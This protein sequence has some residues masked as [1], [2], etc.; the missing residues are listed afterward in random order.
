MMLSIWRYSHLTLAIASFVFILLASV[1]G[2]ILAFEPISEQLKPYA[3]T[4]EANLGKTLQQLQNNYE[5]VLF[6]EIDQNGYASASVITEAGEN[7]TF[8]IHPET[9]EKVG[10]ISP[11]KEIYRFATNLHRSLFLKSLGRFF[12]GLAS[13]LLL[14][15]SIT[16]IFL[17]LKRQGGIRRFFSR[18]SKENR[19]QHNHVYLGRLFLIPIV[20]ITV[21]GTYLSLEKFEL[22]PASESSHQIDFEHIKTTPALPLNEFALFKSI[23]LSEVKRIEFPFSPDPEDYFTVTLKDRELLVNQINGDILSTVEFPLVKLFSNWSL[24][25]HTGRG[26]IV[27]SIILGLTCI[28]LLYFMYSGFAMTFERLRK[29][30]LIQNKYPPEAAEIVILVGSETGN[31]YLAASQLQKAL[32]KRKQKV[33]VDSMN[34]FKPFKNLKHLVILTAT[35]G[36][37]EAPSNASQFLKLLEQSPLHNPVSFSVVGFG[38]LAYENFCQYA[39]EV[40]Q[41]LSNQPLATQLMPLRKIHNQSFEDFKD[42]TKKWGLQI[43]LNLTLEAAKTSVKK[44]KEKRFE[45]IERTECNLDD[46]FLLRLRPQ[47]K[48]K[49]E[50]G[51]LWA[52]TPPLETVARLYSIGKIEGDIVLS[53]KKHEMGK[54]SKLLSELNPGDRLNASLQKNPSFHF[55]KQ[56]TASLLIS[57]GTGIAPFLGMFQQASSETFLFWGGRTQASYSI[58]EPYLLGKES[59]VTKVYS[60]EKENQYVQDVLL[61]E[62]ALVIKTL[63]K[64]GV[65]LICGSVAMQKGVIE[66]LQKIITENSLP[67]FSK[68]QQKGQILMDCY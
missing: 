62:E 14:L 24:R 63:K 45:V 20:I 19:T 67:N 5:E 61:Q 26:S 58:Y 29:R 54:A 48:L 66:A 1:T 9:A 10:D 43:H 47:Q 56:S 34:H 42:W 35:Y 36:D 32:L 11:Q 21:T 13:F 7:E 64:N 50:S 68:L 44:A 31:S 16:G 17:I 51:D 28:S 3:V 33:F 41:A 65:I 40:N 8:Y 55:P 22:V 18:I 52:Y 27:W 2:I 60:K 30:K 25:W 53:I 49:F 12:V 59:Q 39:I 4:K 23:S 57:N 38:S 37:G 6:I 15:I 46:T